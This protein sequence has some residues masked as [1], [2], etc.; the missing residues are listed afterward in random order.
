MRGDKIMEINWLAVFAAALSS[1]VLGGVWYA[2]L[3]AKAHQ[4]RPA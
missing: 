1:F 2:A 3:F 4:R